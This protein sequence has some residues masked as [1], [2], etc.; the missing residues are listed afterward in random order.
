MSTTCAICHRNE[1][2]AIGGLTDEIPLTDEKGA[3]TRRGRVCRSGS[4]R[5]A[6]GCAR[7]EA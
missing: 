4:L 5:C 3:F 6:T 7:M 1:A 2:D